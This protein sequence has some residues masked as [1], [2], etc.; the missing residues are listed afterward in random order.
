MTEACAPDRSVCATSA[1]AAAALGEVRAPGAPAGRIQRAGAAR[2]DEQQLRPASPA[3]AGRQRR[4]L[5]HDVRI[6]AADAERTDARRGAARRR[7]A[8]PASRADVERGRAKSIFGLGA[9]KCSDA[10]SVPRASA[11]AV[12]MTPA[13]P[14]AITR[15]PTLLLT[16]PIAQKPVRSGCRAGTRGQPS[17]SIGSPSGVAVPWA[18]T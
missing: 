2:R 10:G 9:S 3:R 18:S 14:A 15:W 13:A 6:G 17:I 1:S 16:E 4:L 8:S 12:L 5:E 7:A 11:S